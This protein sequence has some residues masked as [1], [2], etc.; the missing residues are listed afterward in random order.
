[1]QISHVAKWIPP[2]FGDFF[3]PGPIRMI[4]IYGMLHTSTRGTPATRGSF[5]VVSQH[6][7]EDNGPFRGSREADDKGQRAAAAPRR[8]P[9]TL[10]T[11][12]L[13]DR[14]TNTPDQKGRRR[15][16]NFPAAASSIP[17]RPG[18]PEPSGLGRHRALECCGHS[19]LVSLAQTLQ[20]FRSARC[21]GKRRAS[22]AR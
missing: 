15:S 10:T 14:I 17:E 4:S 5:P 6:E 9:L 7:W 12:L 8:R 13:I 1:M 16:G 2:F 20:V 19:A 11:Q 18:H 22:L 3:F 21:P